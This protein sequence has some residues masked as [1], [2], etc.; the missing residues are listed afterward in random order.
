MRTT[1]HSGRAVGD[2]WGRGVM[3]GER[4]GLVRGKGGVDTGGARDKCLS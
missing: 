1:G 4:C 3:R 2:T